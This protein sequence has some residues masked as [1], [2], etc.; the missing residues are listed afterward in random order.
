MFDV[1]DGWP[2]M[3]VEISLS[4]ALLCH[5]QVSSVLLKRGGE[6][7]GGIGDGGAPGD[8]EDG[9]CTQAGLDKIKERLKSRAADD[10][11]MK[12]CDRTYLRQPQGA[13]APTPCSRNGSSRA[14][15]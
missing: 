14:A 10:L 2:E 9:A 8:D 5:R 4:R 15:V 11:P 13:G 6:V 12:L 3:P 1:L 7:I